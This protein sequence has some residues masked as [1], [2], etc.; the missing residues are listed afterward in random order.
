MLPIQ[1]TVTLLIGMALGW[2]AKAYAR[3]SVLTGFAVVYTSL[4]RAVRGYQPAESRIVRLGPGGVQPL[5]EQELNNAL[6]MF[7][8][9][10]GNPLKFKGK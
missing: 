7:M 6:S 4:E 1:L 3:R 5:T 10:R 2:V 8:T 9:I